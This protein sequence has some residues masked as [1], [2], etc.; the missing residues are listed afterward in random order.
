[1]KDVQ[2][3]VATCVRCQKTKAA[4]HKSMGLLHPI[5]AGAPG[6]MVTLD[7]VS[8]FAR[9]KKTKHQQCIVAIDKF[10][11]FTFLH[12]F[13]LSV[14][15]REAAAFLFEK[16]FPVLGIPQKVI[17]DRD[18]QFTAALWRE[19]LGSL[20]AKEALAAAHHPQTDGLSERTVR[21]LIHL[22]RSYITET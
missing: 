19:F 10:T 18:P 17:S 5:L 2:E 6:E 11:R 22:L 8:K 20:G 1:M 21:T 7:F 16:V 14:S 4:N 13:S 12:G 9:A 3:Y 15:A